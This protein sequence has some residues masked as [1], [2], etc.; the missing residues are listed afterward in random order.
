VRLLTV[1]DIEAHLEKKREEEERV[2]RDRKERS[3]QQ[4]E[5]E[6]A[7]KQKEQE[8]EEKQRNLLAQQELEPGLMEMGLIGFGKKK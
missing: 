5:T 4:K 7:K 8:E 3:K 2:K 6:R 1:E